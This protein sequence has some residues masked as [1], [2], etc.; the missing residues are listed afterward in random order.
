MRWTS[1][2]ADMGKKRNTSTFKVR[3]PQG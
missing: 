2:A 1:R 3:R